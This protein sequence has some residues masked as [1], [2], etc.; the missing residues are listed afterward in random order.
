MKKVILPSVPLPRIA[1]SCEQ[2]RQILW[3]AALYGL[4]SYDEGLVLGHSPR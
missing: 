1:V 2:R 4:M 3:L